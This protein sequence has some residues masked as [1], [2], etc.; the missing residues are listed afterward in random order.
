[1]GYKT[2]V[3]PKGNKIDPETIGGEII[4]ADHLDRVVDLFF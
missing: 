1:M 3:I 4:V 2:I